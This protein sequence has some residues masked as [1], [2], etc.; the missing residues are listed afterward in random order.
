M[1]ELEVLTAWLKTYH[2]WAGT[3]FV[4]VVEA[5]PGSTGLYPKGLQELSRREDVLGNLSVR[6]RWS[7]QLQRVAGTDPRADALWLMDFQRWV[8]QQS[9]MGRCPIFGDEPKTEQMRAC[10]G[11][12]VSRSQ[13][14]STGY[15]VLLTVDFTK[16]YRGE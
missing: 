4:D 2:G 14:G 12:L 1:T 5:V 9:L 10:E 16:N 13:G 11:S 3:L 8:A 7:F 6:F 15:T